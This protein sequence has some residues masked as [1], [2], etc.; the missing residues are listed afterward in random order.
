M[1]NPIKVVFFILFPPDNRPFDGQITRIIL[2][3][4]LIR[5]CM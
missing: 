4:Y 3:V 1:V 2:T 5:V